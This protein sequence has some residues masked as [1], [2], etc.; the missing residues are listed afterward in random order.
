M[1]LASKAQRL[2]H[3]Q[4]EV[5]AARELRFQLVA[6]DRPD[7]VAAQRDMGAWLVHELQHDLVS[8]SSGGPNADGLELERNVDQDQFGRGV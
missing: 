1:C 6:A 8:S 4:L 3:N 2:S 5:V 7:E